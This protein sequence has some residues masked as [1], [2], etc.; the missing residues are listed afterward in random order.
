MTLH[1]W[2]WPVVE[3]EDRTT[4]DLGEFID[5]GGGYMRALP[6]QHHY[7]PRVVYAV[8]V[9]MPIDLH[10][11]AVVDTPYR[12]M[13]GDIRRLGA[14]RCAGPFA[15]LPTTEFVRLKHNTIRPA[16]PEEIQ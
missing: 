2:Q 6:A 16:D 5:L 3:R 15:P 8:P 7:P 14:S 4:M 1:D 9:S 13:E 11:D 12:L 10:S